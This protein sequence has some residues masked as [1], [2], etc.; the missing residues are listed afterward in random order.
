MVGVSDVA[1]SRAS[2]QGHVLCA[3]CPH[4]CAL[5]PGKK[6]LCGVRAGNADGVA[7]LVYG[8]PAALNIDPIEKKP[9]FHFYPSCAVFSY[10]LQGCN[11]RCRGCQNA[12]LSRGPLRQDLAQLSPG[13]IVDAA[14]KAGCGMVAATYSEP[15]VWAEYAH[16]V[17]AEARLAG[18]KNV[19][20]TGG[21]VNAAVREWLFEP[22]DAANVDLKGFGDDMY[23]SWTGGSLAPVLETI[24]YLRKKP[25]FWLEL[26]TLVVP[27]INDD[28]DMLR[29]EFSWIFSNLGACVPLHLS[30][31]HPAAQ[32]MSI[33]RTPAETLLR[34]RDLAHEAGLKFVYLG[35]VPAENDTWCPDCGAVLLLRRGYQTQQPGLSGDQCRFCSRRLEGVFLAQENS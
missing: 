1:L 31:F 12:S 11:L 15:I 33:P 10:G 20:V 8:R 23:R 26:T 19:M 17:A 22:F 32:A 2:S 28:P 16:D 14:R 21:Y 29:A 5:D 4:G 3:L 6:G 7:S 18:L 13:E 35:N 24:L 27:G 34:A 9:L 25:N 30:A